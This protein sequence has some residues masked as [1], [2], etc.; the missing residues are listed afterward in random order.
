LLLG[1]IVVSAVLCVTVVQGQNGW[2]VTYTS[3]E[4]CALKGSTVDIHCTYSHPSPSA[5]A[6]KRF[7]FTKNQYGKFVDLKTDTNYLDRVYYD[8]KNKN[9][10][11]TIT[12]LRE[13]DSAE[14]KFR[15]I[16]NSIG[17]TGSPGVILHMV[18]PLISVS[19]S[20]SGQIVEGSSVT[21]T[22]SSD[23]NPAANY[24]WYKENGSQQLQLLSEKTQLVFS[25]IQS[26]DSG[27]YQCA[28]E[29]EFA[30]LSTAVSTSPPD[31][32]KLP[33]VSVSP[34]GQIVEGSSVTL[35]CSS[36]ANPAAKYTWYK[37]NQTVHHGMDSIYRAGILTAV[38]LIV[39]IFL[40]AILTCVLLWIS[41]RINLFVILFFFIL[42]TRR[43]RASNQSSKPVERPDTSAQVRSISSSTK[44]GSTFHTALEM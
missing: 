37:E 39:A 3:T 28:A 32:P 12:D 10:T 9:C 36:D 11:L 29:N 14:Y 33:S 34:S 38:G 30:L 25:S 20:P 24:T 27:E 7:W 35:T 44:D 43:K 2:G 16:L 41:L 4:I 26:S 22:C 23:A 15:F 8:C 40:V 42:P 21:L 17:Y 1:M 6:E 5:T 18:L 31:P 19:V 13:S